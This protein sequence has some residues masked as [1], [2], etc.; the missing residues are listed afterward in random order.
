M[1]RRVS[2]FCPREQAFALESEQKHFDIRRNR[3]LKSA[4]ADF[5]GCHPVKN[6]ARSVSIGQL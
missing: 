3:F 6:G 5:L 2:C 1:I 4:K